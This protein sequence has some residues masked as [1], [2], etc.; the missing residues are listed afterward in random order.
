M[1][2]T[3]Q[4]FANGY[5]SPANDEVCHARSREQLRAALS[6][7]AEETTQ[8]YDL[9]FAEPTLAVWKGYE[10]DITD[11]CP[12]FLLTP[13]PRGGMHQQNV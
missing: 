10:E 11:L 8:Y 6:S 5:S 9:D 2:Y 3:Y 7:W 12:D 13:G 1:T 4:A